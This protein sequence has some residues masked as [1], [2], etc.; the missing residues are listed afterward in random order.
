[1]M[2]TVCYLGTMLSGSAIMSDE[3]ALLVA[4]IYEA[5]GALR[6]LG[7]R[8]AQADGLTQARWQVLSVVSAGALT[9][10]QAA[11]RLGVSRQNV[12]RVA[13]DLVALRAAVY[14][15]NPDHRS[16]PLLSLT[17]KGQQ[18]LRSINAR[19]LAVHTRMLE[20]FTEAEVKS[21]RHLLRCLLEELDRQEATQGA[22]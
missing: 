8:T 5:A 3:M 19:A 9:V 12:Q 16:S 17:D 15:P 7:E 11:R 14:L 13:N 10:P 18:V 22:R 20:S 2:T 6:R 4:D 1:M 21:T